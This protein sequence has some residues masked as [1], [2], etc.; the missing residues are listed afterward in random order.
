MAI[1]VTGFAAPIVLTWLG[2]LPYLDTL[3]GR[4]KPYLIWPSVIGTYHVRPLPYNVGNAP[5]LGQTFFLIAFFILNVILC[6]VGYKN[7]QPHIWYATTWREM[8]AYSMWRTGTY[9]FAVL[10]LL[11]LFSGRNNVLLWLTNWSHSTYMLLHRWMARLFALYVVIHSILALALYVDEGSF[12]MNEA[13]AWWIWGVIATLTTVIAVVV[14]GLY[15]RK[16]SYEIFLI[17]HIVLAILTLVGS[18]YHV[19]LHFEYDWGQPQWMY[20]AFAVWFFDRLVRALRVYKNGVR[21]AHITEVGDEYVRIDIPGIR[22]SAAPGKHV[23]A[24]FPTLNPFKPWENHPFSVL[25]TS[26]L[27]SYHHST[28]SRHDNVSEGSEKYDDVEKLSPIQSLTTSPRGRGESTAGVTL[29]VKKMSGTT[30]LLKAHDQLP[31]LLDGPYPNNSTGA[32]LGCD[33]LLLIGGGVGITGLLPWLTAHPNAKLFWS[34]KQGAEPL[35]DA[36]DVALSNV[37]EK[38]VRIGERLDIAALL[39][40]EAN[41]SWEKIGVVVCGPGGLCDDARVA[42]IAAAKK[43]PST[44]ELEIDAFSW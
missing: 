2:Y 37:A 23:Y 30:K 24:Y 9:A 36:L 44:F 18:W 20:M 6:F 4:A 39:A 16:W 41:F 42:V 17:T 12:A 5:T 11:L 35:V 13:M 27:R 29:F 33:R 25:P 1:L 22:W 14:S 28:S 26:L 40:E 7:V 43:G 15:T 19:V 3:V 10:P 34:V 31:T 38:D 32:V 21:R 8:M